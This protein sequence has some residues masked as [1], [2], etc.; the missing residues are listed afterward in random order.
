MPMLLILVCAVAII[1]SGNT[2]KRNA[3][4]DK[5]RYYYMEGQRLKA[6]GSPQE[7]YEYF[8][9]A[10]Q[11]DSS[12]VEAAW[13]YG[14]GRMSLNIDTLASREGLR[15]SLDLMRRFAD[16]Y[17][18]NYNEL[19]LLAYYLVNLGYPEDAK[20]VLK[21]VIAH[22]PER[23]ANLIE[24]SDAYA[25]I[26]SLEE[27]IKALDEYEKI[28]GPQLQ[29]TL[30]KVA[31]M[32]YKGDTARSIAE[33]DHLIK[34]CPSD[35]IPLLVKADFMKETFGLDSAGKYIF[36]ARDMAPDNGAVKVTL[37]NYYKAL[38]D[39]VRYD[40]MMYESL[41]AEDLDLSSKVATLINYVQTLIANKSAKER[42]D[43]LFEVLLNEYPHEPQILQL[44]ARFN[45]VKGNYG[46]AVEDMQYVVDLEPNNEKYWEELINYQ[47]V[48]SQ[49]V[50]LRDT[51]AKA[52]NHVRTNF[53]MRRMVAMSYLMQDSL[54]SALKVYERMLSDTVPGFVYPE[55]LSDMELLRRQ[56]YER[57]SEASDI[58]TEMG[59]A[60]NQMKRVDEGEVKY[61]EALR[62]NPENA[63]AA[64]NLAYSLLE[65]HPD[66]LA[67]PERL[68]KIA[69]TQHPD[70]AT[71]L[72]TYAW[73]LYKMKKYPEAL[74]YQKKAVDLV[75]GYEGNS[76]LFDH[77]GDILFMNQK[78]DEAVEAW[79]KAL[80]DNPENA[81]LK[82]KIK[83]RSPIF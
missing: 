24:L 10:W 59:I 29:L 22:H 18:G 32:V 82:K 8:K 30:R 6:E 63:L 56:S 70:N 52:K 36:M 75:D 37:A 27:A 77:Y 62:L 69:I 15:R 42:G 71:F 68:S 50:A 33:F 54:Q 72:D 2:P 60:Y 11:T 57:L 73:V 55:S 5:A 65:T 41:M 13:E 79:E 4:A 31:V 49:A 25:R 16:K 17:P 38:G 51:Y 34:E 67:E 61:K 48:D 7:A 35:P 64:N 21:T 53:D 1:A 58:L 74:E 23:T 28:E 47:L 20:N 39:S 76:E 80:K 44:S 40:D 43:H 9:K 19:E 45:M 46:K 83:Q 14:D 66:S 3:T 81:N 12:Y 26:D 78:P